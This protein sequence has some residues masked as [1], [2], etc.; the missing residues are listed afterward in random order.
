MAKVIEVKGNNMVVLGLK[1]M[2][3]LIDEHMGSEFRISFEEML[4]ETYASGSEWASIELEHRREL[5]ET[6]EHYRSVISGIRVLSEELACLIRE[7]HLDR[8][9]ISRCA[10]KIGTITR[11][12]L[13]V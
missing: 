8:S 7:R 11:R 4:S 13:N 5:D 1:D 9:E 12:E 6:R 2:L 3:E 10:G